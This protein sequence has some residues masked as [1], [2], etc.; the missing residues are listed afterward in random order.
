MHLTNYSLNKHSRTF[1]Y[2]EGGCGS[3][4]KFSTLNKILSGEGYNVEELWSN[5]DDIIIKTILSAY[6]MLK[7]NYSA[8]FPNHDIIQ[9]CFEILGFD[10]L[11]D[12][13]LRPYILEVNHSP[14]FHTSDVIDKDVKE[15]LI[16]DTLVLL[17]I[18]NTIKRRVLSEDRK[19]V[20][21]R[22]L[23]RRDTRDDAS[24]GENNIAA[25][26]FDMDQVNSTKS[27]WMNQLYW[28]EN[29]ISNFRRIMPFSDDLERYTKYFEVHSQASVYSDTASSKRREECAKK[30]RIE[31]QEKK[32]F[33]DSLLMNLKRKNNVK[34][35][36]EDGNSR[37]FT[38]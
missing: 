21:S 9:A 4:R 34:L 11:I 22:L 32:N 6:P 20:Q 12:H 36:G 33:R 29:H 14:S 3:K 15:A 16:N 10:I 26:H 13:K 19:R 18:S 2:D 37:I 35:T 30:Q 28:E 27:M 8:S 7:H 1:C 38:T 24:L 31:L 23:H 25:D 17:N 5:I